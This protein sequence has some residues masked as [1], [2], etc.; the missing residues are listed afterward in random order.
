MA[1]LNLRGLK[2][3]EEKHEIQGSVQ[4]VQV[5]EM[6][7]D[8]EACSNEMYETEVAICESCG[9]RVHTG[10]IARC[11]GCQHK[12]CKKCLNEFEPEGLDKVYVCD[13]NECKL[14]YI[15]W[16]KGTY[17]SA[18][19]EC[20]NVYRAKMDQYGEVVEDC[21]RIIERLR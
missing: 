5:P 12:G 3:L 11:P 15:E 18:M 8:C 9:A 16:L 1:N 14:H 13:G 21:D 19:V 4:N 6:M 20:S 2:M 17:E 7:G 10:C